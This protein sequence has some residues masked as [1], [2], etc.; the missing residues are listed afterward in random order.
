M[1]RYIIS[2]GTPLK[3]EVTVSGAKNV[4]LKAIV[5]GLL[6]SEELVID[7]VPLISDLFTMK[8]I[9]EGLGAKVDI[10]HHQLRIKADNIT[11]FKVPL[12][13][14]ARLRTSSMVLGPLLA[15]FGQAIIPNPG[16]C[17]IGA[18]PIDRHIKGIESMGAEISY[19]E[20]YFQAKAKKLKGTRYKFAKNSHTG[21]ETLIL[22]AVLAEGET[23]IENAAAEPEVDDLIN[24]LYEMGAKIKRISE[25]R[26]VI[27][28]VDKLYGTKY[29]IMP[30]RNEAVT[31]AIGAIATNGNVLVHGVRPDSLTAFLKKLEEVK[32][33]YEI[34]DQAIRFFRKGKLMATKI[35]TK[36][37]PGFMTDWQAPWAVLASQCQGES[38]IH[39]TIF[40]NRFGYASELIKM[41]AKIT[42]FQ[43]KI[44]NPAK[45]YNFNWI[46]NHSCRFQA[47]KILGPTQLHNAVLEVTD[48]RA[49]ATLVLAALAASGESIIHGIEHIDRGYEIFESQLEK[50]G[51]KIKREK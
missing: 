15:R 16:G 38:I 43:P 48:L 20:G 7:N 51:A 3:G 32:A 42:S 27:L 29:K 50:L 24:L 5:A 9:I 22:A 39:E 35:V 28:G 41:G 6:T 1:S 34:K 4:A 2:G 19:Q 18:R 21:T 11:N 49:G 47:I 44:I 31:Y 8:E 45:F 14:G 12:E 36:P 40:E 10:N 23:V 33:S 25:R 30:D 13:A 46:N 17:R 26:I 37:H